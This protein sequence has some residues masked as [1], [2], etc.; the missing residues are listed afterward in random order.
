[1][2]LS[3]VNEVHTRFLVGKCGGNRPLGRAE[4]QWED[5]IERNFTQIGFEGVNFIFFGTRKEK[6]YLKPGQ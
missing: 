5:N 6:G 1:M 3:D 2:T 4:Q